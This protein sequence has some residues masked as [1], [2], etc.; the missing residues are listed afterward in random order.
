MCTWSETIIKYSHAIIWMR[1]LVLI[2]SYLLTDHKRY[3]KTQ[4]DRPGLQYRRR[5]RIN[6]VQGPG[7]VKDH[8]C[9]WERLTRFNKIA[10]EATAQMASG[11]GAVSLSTV[12]SYYST[13]SLPLF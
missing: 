1:P 11:K 9:E 2:K 12:Y 6:A 13:C 4:P 8:Q 10:I 5:P 7:D 3:N